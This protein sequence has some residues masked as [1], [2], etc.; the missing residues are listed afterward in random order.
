MFFEGGLDARAYKSAEW[1]FSEPKMAVF[2]SGKVRNFGKVVFV[3]RFAESFCEYDDAVG[4]SLCRAA[5][6]RAFDSARELFESN[7]STPVLFGDDGE[8]R[9]GGMR[10]AE[11]EVARIAAHHGDYEPAA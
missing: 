4:A 11:C 1:E 9:A 10:C 3:D 2:V 5:E 6:D 8:G 7:L